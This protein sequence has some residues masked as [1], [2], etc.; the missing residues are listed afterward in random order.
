MSTSLNNNQRIY[1]YR[2]DAT[3]NHTY[4]VLESLSHQKHQ[5]EQ[6]DRDGEDEEC[7]PESPA[8][9]SLNSAWL[10]RGD[11]EEGLDRFL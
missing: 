7:P 10:A 1:G 4:R 3:H 9:N 8:L 5:E 6:T 2:V 11:S